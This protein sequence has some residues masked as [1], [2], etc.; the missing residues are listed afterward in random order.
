MINYDFGVSKISQW[1]LL[2]EEVKQESE[3]RFS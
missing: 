1:M 3:L 2:D